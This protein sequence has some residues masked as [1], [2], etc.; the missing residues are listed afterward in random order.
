MTRNADYVLLDE[1][2][3][4]RDEGRQA[5]EQRE[6][7]RP[8]IRELSPADPFPIDA[9]GDVLGPAARG[10][11]Q[12]IQS[13]LPMCGQSVLAA[14][15]LAVQAQADV[16]LP[17]TG[18]KKPVSNFF[19]TVAAS[20]ER[21][22]ATDAEALWPIHRREA[23]LGE[24][25]AGEKPSYINDKLA[26][27]R[28]REAITRKF[29]SDR[30]AIKAALDALGRAPEALLDPLLT[31]ADPTF[32]GLCRHLTTGQPSMGIFSAEGGQFIGGHGMSVDNKLRTAAGFSLLWDG[33]PLTRVRAGDGTM[34]LPG[35]RMSVHLMAQ[36]D[37]AATMLSDRTL[38]DQGLLSRCLVS[39]PDSTAGFRQWRD[40]DPQAEADVKR[41][42]ARLLDILER[43]LPLASGKLNEL[44]PRALVLS[45]GAKNVLVGFFNEIE[46]Q[47]KPNGAL[48]PIKGLVNKL[49]EHAAR[50]A[51][52]LALVDDIDVA[53][54][55]PD[56]MA[57]GIVLAQY[58]ATEAL[59]LFE[60]GRVS[61]DLQL[62]IRLCDWVRF[63]WQDDLIALPDI[64]QRSLNSIGD[65]ATARRI[66]GI[67]EDHGY[68]DRV[69]GG[70]TLNGVRRKDV[71][72]VVKEG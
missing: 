61:P 17:P 28:A 63:S 33:A 49:H 45:S 5:Q 7:P 15:A 52:V 66:V 20:G 37:V 60:A 70:A 55:S 67:L 46:A 54:V 62:A 50:I 65:K 59:R 14:A 41:Y 53:E 8:L 12:R 47:L 31:C 32:E 43:P 42:G 22:S 10:I 11:H 2:R 71:W 6:P 34:V 27:D 57:D 21:K 30:A 48:V 40:A 72:R 51:A 64:Y 44:K 18:H 36:I 9:L 26:W 68:L 16:E 4:Q 24:K 23:M 56:N 39:A 35:R 3:R 29:K 58:Y 25:Y 38:V 19:V 13:P 69:P 1:A